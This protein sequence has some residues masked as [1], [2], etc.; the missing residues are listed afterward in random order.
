[1]DVGIV[2]NL[3]VVLEEVGHLQVQVEFVGMGPYLQVSVNLSD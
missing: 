3:L 2:E 1:M